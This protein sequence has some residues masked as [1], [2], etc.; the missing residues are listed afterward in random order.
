MSFNLYFYSTSCFLSSLKYILTLPTHSDMNT[1]VKRT[2][3][4]IIMQLC[5][6]SVPKAGFHDNPPPML[7]GLFDTSSPDLPIGAGSAA[8][9]KDL[10]SLIT[11]HVGA[12][13]SKKP[14]EIAVDA[15]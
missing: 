2:Y 13:D 11:A 7:T 4:C 1:R 9:V 8:A 6:G 10:P 14:V 15:V 5:I 3:I 12:A